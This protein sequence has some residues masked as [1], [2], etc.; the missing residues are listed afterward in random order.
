MIVGVPAETKSGETRIALAPAG[1]H[2]LVA[3]GH[4]VVVESGAG[5]GAGIGDDALVAAGATLADAAGAWGSDLVLK[6]KE[7]QPHELPLLCDNVLFTFLHLAANPALATALR[8][9]GTTALSYDTVQDDA[10]GL[11]LLA[12]MS[13]IAGR[14]AVVA[15]AHH[16]LG[17]SGG[18]GILLGGA[19]G[20][21]G[22][23]VVVI[24]AGVAGVHAVAQAAGL[25]ADV[26]ALDVSLPALRRL[27]ERFGGRVR[28]VAS[29]AL[30]VEEAVVSA[31]L[32]VGAVLVPG[33][34]APVVVT[35]DMLEAMT[36]GSVLVDIAIDQG[37]CVA[38]VV[39]T[40]HADPVR[41]LG[42]A[43]VY[44]VANMPAA[45][46][47]TAT[48]ALTN[49][50]LPYALRLADGVDAAVEADRALARGVNVRAGR[51]VH[52]A[53]AEALGE[54]AVSA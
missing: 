40:T 36:P 51:I 19:P 37:G 38:G 24:G 5:A 2:A 3:R 12:P 32:V 1:V 8:A 26:T 10:G 6:V 29:T 47:V 17:P 35:R 11:P 20:V 34:P 18:R 48:L 53:V 46:G 43:R 21:P 25:G 30:A 4:R 13:E 14:L 44:S 15:G 42:R 49:A 9:A 41:R 39:P 52:P 22:A 50:T 27:D 33:R 16:L 31:D 28:T 54:G 45:V 7:P 23:R